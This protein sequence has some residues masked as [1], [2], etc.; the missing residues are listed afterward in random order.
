MLHLLT[1]LLDSSRVTSQINSLLSNLYLKE[2]DLREP[3]PRQ[4]LEKVI[5]FKCGIHMDMS[6]MQLEI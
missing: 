5:H 4:S 3:K 6:V 2:V 1:P